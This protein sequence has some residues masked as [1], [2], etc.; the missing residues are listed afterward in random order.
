MKIKSLILGMLACAAFSACSSDDA[1]VIVNDNQEFKGDAAY[2]NVRLSYADNGTRATDGGFEYGVNEQAVKTAHF[3]FYDAAGQFVTEASVWNDGKAETG[4]PA[5]NIEF[6]SNTVVA[7]K[8]LT[9]KSYPKYVVTILNRPENFAYG[10]TLADMGKKLADEADKGIMYTEGNT[11]Y[12]VMS[13]TSFKQPDLNGNYFVTEVT[14]DDFY[15]EPVPSD[16]STIKP[17]EIYVERLAAKVKLNIAVANEFVTINNEKY[18]KIKATVAGEN[19]VA[20]SGSNIGAEDMYVHFLGWKLNGTAKKSYMMK[21]ID[22]SWTYGT[23]DWDCGSWTDTDNHR[24]YWAKSF[25]YGN[26][27]YTYPAVASNVNATTDALDYVNLNGNLLGMDV[28]GYCA[29]NTNNNTILSKNFPSAVTS[30]LIKAEICDKDGKP[31]DLVRFN[32]VLFKQS[33]FLKYVL[34]SVKSDLPCYEN[35]TDANGNKIYT[36]IDE[37]YVEVVTAGNGHVKVAMKA[38][39]GN[40]YNQ[41]GATYTKDIATI[42]ANASANATGYN[43]GLMYYNVPIQHYNNADIKVDEQTG[44]KEYPEGKYGVVRNHLYSL[45][46][47]RLENPGKGIFDPDETIVP[48]EEDEKFYYVGARINILSWKIVN[49]SVDL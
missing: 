24:S 33:H 21:N 46:I 20:E 12:F 42:L 3:Y 18:Y 10:N 25:N 44:A 49:Q 11:N 9:S 22:E 17:V 2:M 45:S 4:T 27:A 23:P 1:D 6:K 31:L 5:G 19:N 37:N 43:G 38:N 13:T 28:A 26:T 48:N 41:N 36:Q 32:G 40:L 35:G 8:G 39:V 14:K 34:N 7:L 47:D 16:A 15:D 29:E 30:V